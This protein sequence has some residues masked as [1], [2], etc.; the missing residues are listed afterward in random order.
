MLKVSK[1]SLLDENMVSSTT[2]EQPEHSL[3]SLLES[4]SGAATRKLPTYNWMYV[5]M[6]FRRQKMEI[7]S[8]VGLGNHA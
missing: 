4:N 6:L 1:P 2:G 7:K 3:A 8:N 5:L